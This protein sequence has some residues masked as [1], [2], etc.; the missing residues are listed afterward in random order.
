MA[1]LFVALFALCALAACGGDR[2]VRVLSNPGSG[3]DEFGVM[4]VGALEI[5]ENLAALPAPTP[6]GSN[7]TDPNPNGEAIAALGGNQNAAFA[8][9]IPARDQALVAQAGRHGVDPSIRQTL[10]TEDQRFRNLRG[11]LG[12]FSRRDRYFGIYAG[13]SLDAY[14]ELTRFRNLGIAVPSAPPR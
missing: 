3:P 5:P 1:R 9:G 4:P 6:G 2:G 10:A 8:G 12:L 7:L 11:R 13:Q 14:S